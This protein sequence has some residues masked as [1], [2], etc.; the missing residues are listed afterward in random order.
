[1]NRINLIVCVIVAIIIGVSSFYFLYFKKTPSYTVGIIYQA[2][3]NHDV[4]T[5]DY[6]VDLDS[7]LAKA[8]DEIL[9]D[10]I[11]DIGEEEVGIVKN[12]AG[13]LKPVVVSALEEKIRENIAQKDAVPQTTTTP[14]PEQKASTKD[15]VAQKMLDRIK[16][17]KIDF[18]DVGKS[19]VDGNIATIE[20]ILFDKK[21]EQEFTLIAKMHKQSDGHWRLTEI[22]NIADY[23]NQ[24]RIAKTE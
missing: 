6:Y 7:M 17:N 3:R 22:T 8:F 11:K 16:P 5:F 21:I 20:I 14:P 23:L 19:S 15:K 12:F 10:Q 9:K 1:M 13:L 2:I 24:L 4:A 18:K